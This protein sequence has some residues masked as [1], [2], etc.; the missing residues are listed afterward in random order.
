VHERHA[1]ACAGETP[2]CVENTCV[3]CTSEV[4]DAC[5][6][7]EPA[8]GPDNT[9]VQCTAEN[10]VACQGTTPLCDDTSNTCVPCTA[11]DQ[12]EAACDLETGACMPDNAI[13][14]IDGDPG[15]SDTN[16]GTQAEPLCTPQ[17]AIDL[18]DSQGTLV[19]H[20]LRDGYNYQ[21]PITIDRSITLAL[22]SAPQEPRPSL[23]GTI[24]GTTIRITDAAE[25]YLDGVSIRGR[26]A[27]NGVEISGSARVHAHNVWI[28]D[29]GGVGVVVSA[30]STFHASSCR[31]IGNTEGG[32]VVGDDGGPVEETGSGSGSSSS[33]AGF[34]MRV[35]D[36]PNLRLVNCFVNADVDATAI[37]AHEGRVE[38]LYSTVGVTTFGGAH[39]IA[40]EGGASVAVRNSA[41][42]SRSTTPLDCVSLDLE[43]SFLAD[44]D[45]EPAFSA[46]WFQNFNA[47]DFSLT[48]PPAELL[49]AAR[50]QDGDPTTD[51][52][53][54]DRPTTA[55]AVDAAGADT[56]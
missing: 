30:D 4:L 51:I 44:Q 37:A 20:A 39:S 40:C 31:I 22:L 32:I 43:T 1:G 29:N 55:N 7:E 42:V 12:C 54:D 21:D 24:D 34:G 19:I 23:Q 41:V 8:C 2:A 53:G 3:Q 56:P 6:A 28:N 47:G 5:T 9:C 27:H 48:S 36:S 46:T 25:V 15:C 14:H 17:A 10:P 35:L 45:S 52:D 38:V 50:W 49:T 18:V 26:L 16:Q 11:H 13:W 33:G